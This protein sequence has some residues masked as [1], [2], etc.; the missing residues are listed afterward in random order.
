MKEAFSV[1]VTPDWEGLLRCIKRE[2]M[3][4]RVHHIEVL[5]DPEI[6]D[7]ICERYGV[8]AG[9]DESDPFFGERRYVALQSFLGYDYVHCSLQDFEMPISAHTT[10]DTATLEHETGRSFVD[11]HQGPV[12]TWEEFETFPW[13]DPVAGLTRSL[14]WYEQHLPENMCVIGLGG[15][16]HCAEHL[17]WLMGYETLCVALYEQRD[18]VAAISERLIEIYVAALERI[19]QF[20]RVKIIW[21]ADDMGFRTG[22]LISPEHLREFVLPGHKRLADVAHAAGRPYMLHSCGNI[23]GIMDD[24][25]DDVKIDALHSFEDNIE[26]V[27]EAKKKYGHRIA[28]LGGIDMDF[29]CRSS[30]AGVRVRVRE[31]LEQCMPEGGYV[32]GTGN[33]VAN[34]VP[35]ENYLAML[36][37]GRRF[38]A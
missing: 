11:S 35:I 28:V 38:A 26:N 34:Y 3:P 27:V 13:P 7:A 29:L 33:S 23:G 4:K 20:E 6:Y 30:E 5:I 12:T 36:D 2:G 18:L 21:T 24:L 15:F 17:T 32:L 16:G 14:E 8:A 10:E 25:I 9:L 22:T 37:E 31:T 19:L 1:D